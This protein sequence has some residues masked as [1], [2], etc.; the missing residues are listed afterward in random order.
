MIWNFAD[1]PGDVPVT[2]KKM[3]PNK[4]IV[5]EWEAADRGYNTQVEMRF[6]PLSKDETLVTIA[7]G[8]WHENQKALN[9]SYGNCYG[10]MH[11]SCCL[12]AYL[13]HGINLREGFFHN[14]KL[15]Q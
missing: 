3:V 11:M 2:V 7:E 6:E 1:F 15:A 10:W 14:P 9:A 8:D 12:K 5:L 13:E 4:L